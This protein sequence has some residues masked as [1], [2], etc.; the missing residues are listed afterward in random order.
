M[1]IWQL[2]LA[3]LPK[4]EDCIPKRR[5]PLTAPRSYSEADLHAHSLHARLTE[6]EPPQVQRH[7]VGTW[8]ATR[9]GSR[10]W[11]NLQVYTNRMTE[12]HR[13]FQLLR[14]PLDRLRVRE[15]WGRP[16]E[17]IRKYAD[18]YEAGTPFPPIRVLEIPANGGGVMEIDDGHHRY[19]AA[20]LLGHTHIDAWVSY[21]V[22]HN[23]FGL[24]MLYSVTYEYM[25][26][27]ALRAGFDVPD[28]V[29]D[30]APEVARTY[31]E[32]AA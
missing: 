28:H 2:T 29:L 30:A 4:Y 11:G 26:F 23:E 14:L 15:T 13:V 16:R 3:D 9:R 17:T 1:D 22:A 24:E 5:T 12:E 6:T 32:V 7:P 21:G 31:F 8:V 18:W 25:L 20:R 10:V 19:D 27:A